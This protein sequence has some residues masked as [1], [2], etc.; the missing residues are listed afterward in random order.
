MTQS[1]WIH[2]PLPRYGDLHTFEVWDGSAVRMVRRVGNESRSIT[3]GT[4][5]YTDCVHPLQNVLACDADVVA[6]R[7]I[8]G[9]Q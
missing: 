8:G 5:V 4:L 7:M 6:W 9:E 2:A 1:E 3:P